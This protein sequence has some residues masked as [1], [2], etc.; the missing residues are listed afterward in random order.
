MPVTPLRLHTHKPAQRLCILRQHAIRLGA[1]PPLAGWCT[2]K[3]HLSR[4]G[5]I[6]AISLFICGAGQIPR[7]IDQFFARSPPAFA[8][9]FSLGLPKLSRHAW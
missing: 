1:Y 8:A 9:L 4:F 2:T 5:S 7:R 3:E 6:I